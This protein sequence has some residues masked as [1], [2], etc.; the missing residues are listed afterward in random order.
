MTRKAKAVLEKMRQ[1]KPEQPLKLF[2]NPKSRDRV[3]N[4][5]N[6]STLDPVGP[7]GGEQ[8]MSVL[9]DMNELEAG[10]DEFVKSMAP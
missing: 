6:Q 3:L 10:H 1:K 8:G 2:R 7:V 9:K 5:F 4:D